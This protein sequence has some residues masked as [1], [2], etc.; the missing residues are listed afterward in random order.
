MQSNKIDVSS[1]PRPNKSLKRN[2]TVGIFIA[3]IFLIYSANS[4]GF[5]VNTVASGLPDFI[6]LMTEMYPP[7]WGTFPK[8]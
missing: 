8:F 4:T 5:N 2:W 1:L 6:N 7:N 3:F